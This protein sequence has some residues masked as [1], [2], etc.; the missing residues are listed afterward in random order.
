MVNLKNT[1]KETHLRSLIKGITWR[2]IATLTTMI[3]VFILTGNFIISLGVGFFEI[4][5]KLLFYYLHE[6]IW[7]RVRWGRHKKK[8]K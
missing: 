6:R 4:I 7:D 3:L 1:I 2:I 5:S 8:K